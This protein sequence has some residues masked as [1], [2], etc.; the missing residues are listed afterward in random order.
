MNQMYCVITIRKDVTDADEGQRLYNLITGL[1]EPV[2]NIEVK[3][4]VTENFS[5]EVPPT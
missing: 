3:G 4:H 2:P 5:L 1:I